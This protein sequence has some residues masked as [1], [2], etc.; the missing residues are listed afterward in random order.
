M[1]W[2]TRWQMRWQ[3]EVPWRQDLCLAAGRGPSRKLANLAACGGGQWSTAGGLGSPLWL[4]E[5]A[6]EG[7]PLTFSTMPVAVLQ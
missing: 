4:P 7:R 6:S 1:R 3:K 2:Q 5:Q